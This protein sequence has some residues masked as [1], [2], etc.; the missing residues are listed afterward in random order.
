MPALNDQALQ[1]LS[2]R[3]LDEYLEMPG[4]RLTVRQAQQ[5]FGLD[6]AECVAVLEMLVDGR[7]LVRHSDG[8]Y[9]R[10]APESLRAITRTRVRSPLAV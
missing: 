1:R 6:E 5:L 2:R 10:H 8:T 7:A 9:T 4:L 3:I